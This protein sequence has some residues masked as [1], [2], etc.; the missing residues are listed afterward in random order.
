LRFNS[1][2]QAIA[3]FLVER[4]NAFV[5]NVFDDPV[6]PARVFVA[7]RDCMG[8]RWMTGVTLAR[9]NVLVR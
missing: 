2:A 9:E 7:V 5:L 8:R 3:V 6:M 1:R 4:I